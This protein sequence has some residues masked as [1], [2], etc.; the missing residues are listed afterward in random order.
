MLFIYLF[1]YCIYRKMHVHVCSYVHTLYVPVPVC[2][3]NNRYLTWCWWSKK[4]RFDA[5]EPFNDRLDSVVFFH[6][7]HDERNLVEGRSK[8]T[9][10]SYQS[11]T[12]VCECCVD[13]MCSSFPPS[14][15][16]LRTDVSLLRITLPDISRTL[17]WSTTSF[18]HHRIVKMLVQERCQSSR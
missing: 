2:S 6:S 10:A 15:A 18:V 3:I 16:L 17:T 12:C 8:E 5:S 11:G 13:D 4:I 7:S 9:L 1:S 14:P